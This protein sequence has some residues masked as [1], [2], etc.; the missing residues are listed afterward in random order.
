M[1]TEQ[2]LDKLAHQIVD[3]FF[4]EKIALTNSVVETAQQENLNPEQIKRLVES[5]NNLT[6][7]KKFNGTPPG[8]DRVIEFETANSD[9]AIQRLLDQAQNDTRNIEQ[10]LSKSAE[11]PSKSKDNELPFSR[12]GAPEALPP[13][14]MESEVEPPINLTHMTLKL[15]KTAE[16]LDEQA[17]QTRMNLT[18]TLEKL[19][20]QFT[21]V[22]GPDF[23]AFEKDAFY[24]WGDTAGP[25][26]QLLR[27]SLRYPL[28]DY[29]STAIT[30]VARVM[31]SHTVE[32]Q[33]LQSLM[34]YKQSIDQLEASRK[35]VGEYL[36]RLR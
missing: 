17:Y 15:R 10:A 22:G 12:A 33:Q 30:K 6:F 13:K 29:D 11:D 26:L 27:Q 36:E 20:T 21:R 16:L 5:V 4:I 23:I 35:K 28:A 24:T 19:A 1:M 32:M 25:Y 8:H 14:P 31:D 3:R 34:R 7:L 9:A 18:N 2:H